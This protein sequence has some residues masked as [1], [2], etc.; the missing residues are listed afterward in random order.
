MERIM[1]IGL[2]EARVP[3]VLIADDDPGILRF[4]A[5]RVA[6]LG[7]K[8]QTATNGIQALILATQGHPDV[9]ITDINMPEADGLSLT[10]RLLQPNRTPIDVIVITASSYSDSLER[11]E[12]FGAFYV[13]KGED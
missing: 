4:I 13:R 5:G 11:C 9:L 1:S 3:R 8:V 2:K 10:A 12:S 6:K 7:F